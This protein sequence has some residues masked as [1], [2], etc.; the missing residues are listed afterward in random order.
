MILKENLHPRISK[1][2]AQTGAVFPEFLST[3]FARILQRIDF[4]WG[5]KEAITYFESLIL[6]DVPDDHKAHPDGL[7][8]SSRSRQGFP[9]EAVK[10]IVLLKQVHQLLFPSL[11]TI[12]PFD[13]FSGTE[14]TPIEFS[15]KAHATAEKPEKV[16]QQ[17]LF[18]EQ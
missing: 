17:D 8:H 9:L 16:H 5:E 10:E 12:N 11:T 15:S 14:I 6:G 4:L 1:A 18:Q 7:E 2:L 13:P 3:H